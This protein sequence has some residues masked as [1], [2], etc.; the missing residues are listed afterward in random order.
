MYTY[1][2]RE[3]GTLLPH[4]VCLCV[5]TKKRPGENEK[6]NK[7]KTQEEMEIICKKREKKVKRKKMVGLVGST[8]IIRIVI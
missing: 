2:E 1:R 4:S 7:T 8:Y 3:K 5:Y 6:T